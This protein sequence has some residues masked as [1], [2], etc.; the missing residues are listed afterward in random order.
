MNCLTRF[1]NAFLNFFGAAVGRAE[2]FGLRYP[3][4]AYVSQVSPTLWRGSRPDRADM[5][6]MAAH[7]F[8]LCVSLCAE[9]N[10]DEAFAT[11]LSIETLRIPVIDNTP[12]TPAQVAI[13]LRASQL[14]ECQPTFVH[15]EAGIG[16]T[17]VFVACYRVMVQGWKIDDA[18]SE[19]FSFGYIVP[20]QIDF[21]KNF[22]SREEAT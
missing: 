21:I 2:C 10:D 12:P 6:K 7:G 18:L 19:A 3:V 20:D 16:R 4:H 9:N 1:K 17:G 13:F 11:G 8:K 15:C 22:C 5:R 14:H